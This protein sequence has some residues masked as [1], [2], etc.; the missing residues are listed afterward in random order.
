[1]R[2]VL[3][4]SLT[5][6]SAVWA[7][8]DTV[9]GKILAEE[10]VALDSVQE[11]AR[12]AARSVQ[13]FDLQT[14][15]DVE[16]VR[17]TWS[18]D[19]RPHGVRLRTKLRLF[20]FETV[21]TVSQDAAREGRNRTARHIAP[22]LCL[23][24]GAARADIHADDSKSVLQRLA[25]RVPISRVP[26][27]RVPA[28]VAAAVVAAS[29][30]GVGIGLYALIGTAPSDAP[31][32]TAA[33]HT[34]VVAAPSVIPTPWSVAEPVAVP[35]PWAVAEPAAVPADVAAPVSAP[36]PAV[37]SQDVWQ[38]D[39]QPVATA[40]EPETAPA[41]EAVTGLV[42]D[43]TV[44]EAIPATVGVPHLPGVQP[45]A[46]PVAAPVTVVPQPA[47]PPAPPSVLS[48]IFRALP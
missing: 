25:A 46:V 24:Y 19:A 12:A 45:V 18:E 29:A 27:P 2:L 48:P 35:T 42:L 37:E 47:A 10:V 43:S 9:N 41:P 6:S 5:A 13:A 39:W 28:R 3:G 33:E 23:A 11:L 21:E 22:H 31:A 14:E 20:G 8:V 32:T 17:M 34:P 44:P 15:H 40:V 36:E 38:D 26:I 7:L 4:M 1:M 30:V 16:G